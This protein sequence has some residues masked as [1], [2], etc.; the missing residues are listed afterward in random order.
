MVLTTCLLCSSL[1]KQ[2]RFVLTHTFTLWQM[3]IQVPAT[4]FVSQSHANQRDILS[5]FINTSLV[6][7]ISHVSNNVN[8]MT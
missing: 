8:S 4:E 3:L 5:G 2:N 1:S 7:C 6:L